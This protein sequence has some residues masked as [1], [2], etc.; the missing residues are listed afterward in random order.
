MNEIAIS[1]TELALRRFKIPLS[2]QVEYATLSAAER[3][4][5]FDLLKIFEAISHAK[6]KIKACKSLSAAMHGK[7]GFKWKTIYRLYGEYIEEYNWRVCIR[8][9]RGRF[10]PKPQEFFKFIGKLVS[11]CA[12]RTDVGVAARD[13]LINDF[14]FAG[15]EVPG[16]GTFAQFWSKTQCDKPIPRALRDVPPFVP[17]GWS[18]SRI[19]AIIRKVSARDSAV[20]MLTAHSFHATHSSW[21]QLLRD[22]SKLKPMQLVTFDDVELDIQC[23]FK[24]KN[25]FQVCTAQAVMALDVATG[26]I[27]GHGVRP[28]YKDEDSHKKRYLTRN[29]VNAVFLNMLHTHGLP[30]NY[31]MHLLLENAAATFNKNDRALLETMFPG[32]FE[33]ENTRMAD[34]RLLKNGFC[35]SHGLPYQKGWIEAAFRPLHTRL[36]HLPGTTGMRYDMRREDHEDKVKYALSVIEK[37]EKKGIEIERLKFPVLTEDEFLPILDRIVKI[38]N[39]RTNHKLQGF[40]YVYETMLDDCSFVRREDCVDWPAEMLAGREFTRRLESPI[41]RFHKLAQHEEFVKVS[42][43]ALFPLMQVKREVVVR[44]NRITIQDESFSSERLY[45]ESRALEN[46]HGETFI[47]AFT[48]DHE[49]AW[50]FKKNLGYVCAVPRQGRIDI[51]NQSAIT[52]QSGIVHRERIKEVEKAAEMLSDRNNYYK[53]MRTHNAAILSDNAAIGSAMIES[54]EHSKKYTRAAKRQLQNFSPENFDEVKQPAGVV[55][56]G[57]DEFD[58]SDIENNLL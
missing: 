41:E 24:V 38:F 48:A 14:W 46:F 27:V 51:T 19:A 47:A 21:T 54:A 44:N 36:A 33:I 13:R 35:E 9:Y 45:Y 8:K 37:A 31:K 55:I 16:Y 53:E 12:G 42:M 28:I 57:G 10:N 7:R 52:R 58:P 29:E 2:D 22:K 1:S 25:K 6:K 32:N 20:R 43:S 39:A 49:T 18:Y 40:D 11:E 17:E 5:I 34:R 56:D 26:M 4:R 15:K 30:A 3:I 50:L 23:L